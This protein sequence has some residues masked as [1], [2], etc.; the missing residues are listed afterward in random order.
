[1]KIKTK[2]KWLL[3]IFAIFWIAVAI[4]GYQQLYGGKSNLKTI[5][6]GYLTADPVDIARQRGELVKKMKA[7][8]YNVV[9]KKFQDGS[10]EMQALKSGSIDYARIGDTPPITVLAAG[11]NLVYVAAGTS[12]AKG[13]G[14][15]VPKG[16]SIKSIADLKGKRIAYTKSTSSHYL[17]LSALKKAGLSSDDVTWVNLDQSAA[18]VAFSKGKVDAW[19]T[20]DPMTATAQLDQGA[21]LLTT[22]ENGITSNRD[23]IVTTQTFADSHSALSKELI[24][25]IEDDMQWANK[26]HTK[27]IDM[28]AKS[29]GLSKKV[30]KKMVDRHTYGIAAMDSTTIAEEQNVA[31]LFYQEGLITEKVTV[32]DHIAK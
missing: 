32:K 25:Y 9:F 18:S 8:G 28:L 11:T 2:R 20:W 24:D 31:D 6:L 30:I 7:K 22:G 1:M 21:T 4:F 27:L 26:H 29:L 23:Y 16:S 15:L 17:V 13:T 3:G 10:A 14:I 5:T 12:R 19:A